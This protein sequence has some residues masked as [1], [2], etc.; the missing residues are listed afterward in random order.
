MA[1]IT[2]NHVSDGSEVI[3]QY[4]QNYV[5]LAGS[6]KISGSIKRSNIIAIVEQHTDGH[7]LTFNTELPSYQN[8]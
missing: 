6:T 3:H 5:L 7:G 2:T 1:G 4:W 8:V